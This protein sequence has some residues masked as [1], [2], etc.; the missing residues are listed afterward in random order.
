MR[1]LRLLRMVPSI[2][3]ERAVLREML[4]DG[5]IMKAGPDL[6]QVQNTFDQLYNQN[7]VLMEHNSDLILEFKDLNHTLK[8]IVLAAFGLGTT[9][10]LTAVLLWFN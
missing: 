7:V 5:N 2:D 9:T 1:K 6:D 3:V 8:L 10:G 4:C